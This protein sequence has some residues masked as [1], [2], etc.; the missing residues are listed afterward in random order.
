MDRAP[1]AKIPK[2]ER[3]ELLDNLNYS[4]TAEIK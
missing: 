1:I 3:Q 2:E 4:N